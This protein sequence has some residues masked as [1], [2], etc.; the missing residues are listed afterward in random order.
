MPSEVDISNRALMQAGTRGQIASLTEAS[1]EARAC[2]MLFGPTRDTA[3]QLAPWDFA[4]ASDTL[5]LM[6]SAPGTPENPMPFPPI[7]WSNDY[8]MPPWNYMYAQPNGFVFVRYVLPQADGNVY[9]PSRFVKSTT[10]S[11]GGRVPVILTNATKAICVYTVVLPDPNTWTPTF[12]EM[13]VYALAARLSIP[14]S[15]DKQ[16]AM[17]NL[18]A[19]N[20]MLNEARV[21]DGNESFHQQIDILTDWIRARDSIPMPYEP[22]DPLAYVGLFQLG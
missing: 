17:G 3:L 15:G 19:A 14:L 18:S 16:L 2:S 22:P 21:T 7:G 11:G 4:R 20:S 6:T 10:I 9:G 1:K 8:P 12:T 5:A 13:F